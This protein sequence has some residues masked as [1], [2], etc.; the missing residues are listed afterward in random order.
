V[1]SGINHAKATQEQITDWSIGSAARTLIESPAVEIEEFYQRMLSGILDAIPVAVYR[2]F[3]FDFVDSIAAHGM[4]TISFSEPVVEAFTIPSGTIFKNPSTGVAYV[5][6]SDRFVAIGSV[7]ENI[8]V[9][10]D[11]PGTEGNAGADTITQVIGSYLPNTAVLS[12]NAI[13]SGSDGET[14]LERMARFSEF[15][16]AL[17]RGTPASVMHAVRSAR[18]VT[19]SGITTEYVTRVGLEEMAGHADVFIYGSG[20]LPSD[21]LLEKAQVIVD[22]EILSGVYIEGYRPVG[23]RVRVLPMTE[24][25]I[26]I[27]VSLSGVGGQLSIEDTAEIALQTLFGRVLSGTTILV[28][29]IANTLLSIA[30]VQKA[31]VNLDEHISVASN[32]VLKLGALTVDWS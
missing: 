22:G 6:Q 12:N 18:L 20:G 26:D 15:V 2:A 28:N 23:V 21:E 29:E 30:G 32:E 5:S 4:V 25:I 7:L 13:T 1:L 31:V 11:R 8:L 3:G 27:S 16:A 19:E 9:V 17:A 24:K 14:D 10:A